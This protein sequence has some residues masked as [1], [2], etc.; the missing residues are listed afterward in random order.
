M[1]S[2]GPGVAVA[3]TFVI[4]VLGVAGAV[5][6]RLPD[7]VLLAFIYFQLLAYGATALC[8][9]FLRRWNLLLMLLVERQPF[10]PS[11]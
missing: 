11:G 9:A 7:P 3:F 1:R 2:V 10:W 5:A 4:P 8:C 6:L